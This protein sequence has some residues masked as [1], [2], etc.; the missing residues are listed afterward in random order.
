LGVLD[1]PLGFGNFG[2]GIPDPFADYTPRQSI[3]RAAPV[4][5]R[6]FGVYYIQNGLR[7]TRRFTNLDDA[8]RFKVNAKNIEGVTR[9]SEVFEI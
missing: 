1:D 5:K 3:Q 4:P 2:G 7:R 8:E 9:V 6:K